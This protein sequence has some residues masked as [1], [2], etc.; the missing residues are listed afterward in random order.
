M[1]AFPSLTGEAVWLNGLFDAVCVVAVFPALV[2][3]GAS[4][5][6][7]TRPST[8]RAPFTLRAS[9]ALGELSYP[10][11]AVHYP[12]MYLFYAHIGFNGE[13]SVKTIGDV[14]PEAIALVL[15]SLLLAWLFLRLYD[16]PLR[17]WL[18]RKWC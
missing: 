14:W 8:G 13:A 2:C 9:H 4:D 18:S 7:T 6:L 10:L 16:R 5:A 11:Y 1:G 15:G 3:L 17:R 12:L